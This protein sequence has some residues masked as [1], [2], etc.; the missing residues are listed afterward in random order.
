MEVTGL[1]NLKKLGIVISGVT[2]W[3]DEVDEIVSCGDK[4]WKI[5]KVDRVHQGCWGVPKTRLHNLKLEP[6]GHDSQPNVGDILI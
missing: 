5:V 1:Y 2:A 3:E 4:Q 6:I